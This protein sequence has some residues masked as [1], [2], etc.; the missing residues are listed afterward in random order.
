MGAQKWLTPEERYAVVQ[1]IREEIVKDP[2]PE[3]YF[4]VT[5]NYLGQLPKPTVSQEQL[6]E[7]IRGRALSG[8]QKYGQL[9]FSENLG[10]YGKALYSQVKEH[11]NSALT[12][13]LGNDVHLSYNVHRMSTSAAWKGG[14][15]LSKSK[16]QLY[17]GE[18]RPIVEGSELPGMHRMHWGFTGRYRQLN[19]LV[20][21]RTPFPSEWLH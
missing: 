5:D 19:A 16:Y 13:K 14:F 1:Y 8:S 11:A 10:D 17:R 15:D 3:S 20:S 6:E 4:E 21:D 12:I 7:M 2:N 18:E 9:Y